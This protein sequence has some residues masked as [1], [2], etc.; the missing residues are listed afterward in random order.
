M[1]RKYAVIGGGIIGL[2]TA[3][4]L[5]KSHP[6][7][8]VVVYEKDARPGQQQTTHNS[9]VLHCGLYYKPGSLK[10]RLAVS[11]IR[12][13]VAFCQEHGI[14]HEICGKLVVA[15]DEAEVVRLRALQERGVANGLSGLEWLDAGPMREIEPHV[16]GIAALRVPQEGI[17]DYAQVVV[18][19]AAEIG[20][21][22]GTIRCNA[23]LKRACP[24]GGGWRLETAAGDFAADFL[25]NCGGL[26]SDRVAGAAGE[27]SPV[28]IVPFRGEYYELR[29]DRQFLVRNLIYPVPD[30]TFPFLGVHFTR[31][32]H[33][34]IEAGP[35]AVLAWAREGYRKTDVNPFDLWDALSFPGLWKF[36]NKHRRMCWEEIERSWSKRL[37]CA[38]LQRLVPDV[39]IDDLSAGGAGVRAQAMDPSGELVQDFSLIRRPNALHVVNAPSPGA[40]AS[41]AIGEEIVRLIDA[42]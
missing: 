13:M 7:A 15:T 5:L 21:L 8:E 27:K 2:A 42:N 19:M 41:L 30:P 16:A 31:L 1:S 10:A 4:K 25:I 34:G 9:G 18:A 32:I 12:E 40:T 38:S 20:R 28:K 37:F 23:K 6:G 33:G 14:A 3:I 22:G 11:G 35:N 24:E 39:R 29:P 36:L 26:H 17:V